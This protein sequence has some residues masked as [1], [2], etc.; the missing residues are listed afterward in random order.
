NVFGGMVSVSP[1]TG[2][3]FLIGSL[4]IAIVGL[5]SAILQAKVA[6]AGV[7]LIAKRPEEVGKAITFAVIVE[8]YAVLALL[9]S[10][11]IVYFIPVA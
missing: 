4:P 9:A 1:Q 10:F 6:A 3:L 2:W 11:L 5:I 8:T 7:G